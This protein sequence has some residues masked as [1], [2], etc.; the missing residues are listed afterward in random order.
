MSTTDPLLLDGTG[1]NKKRKV[2]G[3]WISFIGRIV[4]QVIGA[5]ASILLFLTFIQPTPAGS[6]AASAAAAVDVGTGTTRS[7]RPAIVRDSRHVTIAVLPLANHSGDA[8]QDFLA[9]GMTQALIADLAQIKRLHVISRTSVRAYDGSNKSLPQIADELGADVIVEGA[10]VRVGDQLRVSVQLI[11][12][13]RDHH[14]WTGT[15]DRVL[16]DILSIEREL[17]AEIAGQIRAALLPIEQ[18]RI[19]SYETVGDPSGN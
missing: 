14:L 9:Q 8:N 11:D 12:G 17:S 19:R 15:Y 2:R 4:A 5:A 1:G 7:F 18:A 6:A 10:L 13:A 16:S 3:S